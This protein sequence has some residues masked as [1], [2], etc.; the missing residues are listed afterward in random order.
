MIDLG[1]WMI[2]GGSFGFD[3]T[4]KLILAIVAILICVYDWK[5]N[6]RK[7]YLWV[8]LIGILIWTAVEIISQATG[9]REMP[10]HLLFGIEIPYYIGAILQGAAEGAYV[11]VL[12]LFIADSFFIK[13]DR[14]DSVLALI[15]LL[16]PSILGL[17]VEGIQTP[18]YGGVVPSRRLMFT[19]M[20]TIYL[21]ISIVVSVVWLLKTNPEFRRR[22]IYMFVGMVAIAVVF[23]VF[24][25]FSGVRWI[26]VGPVGG[27][28]LHAPLL[29]EF[30]ALNYDI[31]I[32]IAAAYVPFLVLPCVFRLI[33][34]KQ[35]E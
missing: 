16:V 11:A 20:A 19:P 25:Y 15:I 4:T 17:A 30:G 13:R 35:K 14:R 34:S 21:A 33:K 6:K 22:A 23:T 31:F 3:A 32:E 8:F 28:W 10:V 5:K 7:D 9:M 29:T 24:D 12:G 27:P 26:E 18:D 2:R 1:I